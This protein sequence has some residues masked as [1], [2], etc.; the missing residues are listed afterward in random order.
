MTANN[1][2]AAEHFDDKRAG[3]YDERITKI[4]PAYKTMHDMARYLLQ[5]DLPS[6]TKLLVAGSG[7]GQE[8]ISYSENNPGWN[9]VG[10]D[11]SESMHAVARDKIRKAGLKEKITLVVGSIDSVESD[12]LFDAATSILI[13]HFLPDDGA[14]QHLLDEIS[15]RLKPGARI[16]L[17]DQ[18]GDPKSDDFKLLLKAWKAHQVAIW[19]DEDTVNED[20]AQRMRNLTFVPQERIRELLN[21]AGFENICK[22]FKSFLLGGYVATKH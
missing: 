9:I 15:R 1:F 8:V 19:G 2:D 5:I 3:R 12:S 21:N 10:F 22:F 16:V 11:P 17:I 13:M 4:Q 18:E 20:F 14:K 6:Q 7:T